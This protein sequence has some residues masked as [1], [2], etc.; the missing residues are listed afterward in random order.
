MVL[1]GDYGDEVCSANHSSMSVEVS[2]IRY[3]NR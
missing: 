2:G 3:T 1:V